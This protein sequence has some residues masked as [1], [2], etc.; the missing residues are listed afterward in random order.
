MGESICGIHLVTPGQAIYMYRSVTPGQAIACRAGRK[1]L[2]TKSHF[3]AAFRQSSVGRFGRLRLSQKD[4]FYCALLLCPHVP[5][6]LVSW[7]I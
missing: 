2:T 7:P 6:T 1:S 5:T 3:H 4:L